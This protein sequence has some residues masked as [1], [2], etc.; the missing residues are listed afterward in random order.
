[1]WISISVSPYN[2]DI[3]SFL[4]FICFLFCLVLLIWFSHLF[5]FNFN[6]YLCTICVQCFI[7]RCF[8]IAS[9]V[10]FAITTRLRTENTNLSTFLDIF[11]IA[12]NLLFCCCCSVVNETMARLRLGFQRC[13][14]PHSRTSTKAQQ[15]FICKEN[16]VVCCLAQD[17][18]RNC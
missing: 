14:L 12:R 18:T 4:T 8:I 6:F 16:P 7:P 17:Q 11:R 9:Y 3:A 1:M 2:Y 13:C 15:H 10:R 5:C